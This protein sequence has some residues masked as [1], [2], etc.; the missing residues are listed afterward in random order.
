MMKAPAPVRNAS[1]THGESVAMLQ[2]LQNSP[3]NLVSPAIPGVE[4]R[5]GGLAEDLPVILDGLTAKQQRIVR[6]KQLT[7]S[8]LASLYDDYALRH[9][10]ETT[11]L[12]GNT[13]T[14]FE[15]QGV[16]ES[17]STIPGKS[18]REHLEVVNAHATW[19]WLRPHA[20]D[21]Q[22]PL[23]D[24]LILEIHRRLMQGIVGDEAGLYRRSAVYIRG[25][26]HVPPNWVK[27]PGRV[28]EWV[29]QCSRPHQG[30][31]PV[32]YAARGHV[33]LVAIHPFLDGNGRTA[34]LLVNFL[35]MHRGYPPALYE[36]ADRA[37]YLRALETAHTTGNLAPFTEVTAH[38]TEIMLDRWLGLVASAAEES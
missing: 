14:L 32:S 25:S 3:S 5:T 4:R 1:D 6:G 7:A 17:G 16:I 12:E 37:A 8:S 30:E 10:H 11:A 36:V 22:E 38:A 29:Q 26:R 34:R 21:R 13:L 24:H 9:A 19:Q 23:S 35:L 27:V 31:Y 18:L 28:S 33:A 20:S 15:A 2:C